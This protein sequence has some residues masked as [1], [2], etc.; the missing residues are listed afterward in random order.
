MHQR[1]HLPPSL[2][3]VYFLNAAE[4]LHFDIAQPRFRDLFNIPALDD[5]ATCLQN[6][7]LI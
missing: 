1:A 3:H 5:V 4:K 2:L 6:Q 7:K